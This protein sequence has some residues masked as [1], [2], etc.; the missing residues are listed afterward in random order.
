MAWK[1]PRCRYGADALE[2][3]EIQNLEIAPET[4]A[5]HVAR[6]SSCRSGA[7]EQRA[8]LEPIL[9]DLL[10]VI[11]AHGH[12]VTLRPSPRAMTSRSRSTASELWTRSLTALGTRRSTW[13]P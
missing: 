2:P 5:D 7:R 1:V 3:E 6:C 4:A 9:R 10:H 13:T 12:A 8:A 11:L